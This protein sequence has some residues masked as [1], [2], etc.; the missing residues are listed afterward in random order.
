M[1]KLAALFLITGLIAGLTSTIVTAQLLHAPHENPH[2]AESSFDSLSFIFIYAS[3]AE[4]ILEGQYENASEFIEDLEEADMPPELIAISKRYNE[5]LLELS[6][7]L[8][9]LGDLM[10]D[11]HVLFKQN[12]LQETRDVLNKVEGLIGEA[13]ELTK[14]L[15]DATETLFNRLGKFISGLISDKAA[16]AYEGLRT[17]VQRFEQLKAEYASI[18]EELSAAVQE[19]EELL[20]PTEV[21]LELD[22]VA[23]AFLGEYIHVSGMLVSESS[24]LSEKEIR[25]FIG[26]EYDYKEKEEDEYAV[27]VLSGQDGSYQADMSVP[28]RYVHDIILEAKYVPTGDDS[29]IYQGC[30]SPEVKFQAKFYHTE[31]EFWSPAEV[32][33]GYPATISG[34]V[35]YGALNSPERVIQAVWGEYEEE[36][37]AVAEAV[38]QTHFELSFVPASQMAEGSYTMTIIIEPRGLYDGIYQE[39]TLDVMKVFPQI[40]VSTPP[41]GVSS[42]TIHVEGEVFSDELGAASGAEVIVALGSASASGETSVD[43]KFSIYLDT[44]LDLNTLGS[45]KVSV[46]VHPTEPWFESSET[47][48]QMF[49]ASPII[50]ALLVTA[51]VSVGVVAYVG[52]GR[53]M[54]GNTISPENQVWTAPEERRR[55]ARFDNAKGIMGAY[56]RALRVIGDNTGATLKPHMTMREFLSQ[57]IRDLGKVAPAFEELTSLAEKSLYSAHTLQKAEIARSDALCREI[58]KGLRK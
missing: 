11:A 46:L 57:V 47:S 33:P 20:T 38:A 19:E 22:G 42:R 28:Y 29:N 48:V 44:P 7:K 16:N 35:T 54:G 56:G 9:I 26:P 6:E 36:Y 10:D 15:D 43:G 18:W 49:I 32:H 58:E 23:E 53:M 55:E 3:A 27:I 45:Q 50:L 34:E 31:L 2:E 25:I 5:L 30:M 13:D 1:R 41:V 4:L 51:F 52:R 39:M 8:E 21:T 12:Q 14:E 24:P 37:E 17:M 40:Q